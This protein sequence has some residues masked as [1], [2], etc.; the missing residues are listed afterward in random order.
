MRKEQ[1]RKGWK[2]KGRKKGRN[3]ERRLTT[4]SVTTEGR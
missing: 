2:K 3:E 1:G 4:L